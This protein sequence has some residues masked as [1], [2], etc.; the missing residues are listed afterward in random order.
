[1]QGLYSAMQELSNS[2]YS[3]SYLNGIKDS[4]NPNSGSD[5]TNAIQD[6]LRAASLLGGFGFGAGAGGGGAASAASSGNKSDSPKATGAGGGGG[7]NGQ[8][9]S[10]PH[11]GN[12]KT[13]DDTNGSEDSGKYL[14]YFI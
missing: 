9:K 3:S 11:K 10:D 6:L 4:L 7:E 14:A 13:N 2:K 8:A 12:G 1:M 5:T